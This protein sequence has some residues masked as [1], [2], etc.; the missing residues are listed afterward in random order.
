MTSPQFQAEAGAWM[1][2]DLDA[3]IEHVVHDWRGRPLKALP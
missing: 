3:G 1:D 2:E